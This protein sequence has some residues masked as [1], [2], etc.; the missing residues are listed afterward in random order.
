MRSSRE[1]EPDHGLFQEIL[2]PHVEPTI[3]LQ[4]SRL[5]LGIRVNAVLAIAPG[6]PLPGFNHPRANTV[7][8]FRDGPIVVQFTHRDGRDLDVNVDAVLERAGQFGCDICGSGAVCRHIP[9]T[10]RRSTRRDRGS[11]RQST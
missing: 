9:G 8:G 1:A 11:S 7:G 5:Q 3:P 2:P 10:D 4:E 6:L